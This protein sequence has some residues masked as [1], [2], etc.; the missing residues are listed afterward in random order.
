MTYHITEVTP[1]VKEIPVDI[2]AVRLRQ[3]FRD[4]LSDGWE[5][6]RFLLGPIAN[7]S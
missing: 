7:I 1:L 2:D 4:Q 3:V 6:R 5:M